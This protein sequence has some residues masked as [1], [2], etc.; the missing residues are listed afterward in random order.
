[1]YFEYKCSSDNCIHYESEIGNWR[2]DNVSL[3]LQ[4]TNLLTNNSKHLLKTRRHKSRDQLKSF[5]AKQVRAIWDIW[6]LSCWNIKK[7]IRKFYLDITL[8]VGLKYAYLC[9]S[10]W[11]QDENRKLYFIGA[12][13]ALYSSWWTWQAKHSSGLNLSLL[14]DQNFS[15]F[16]LNKFSDGLST[17]CE[18]R[19]F[20]SVITLWEKEQYLNL[21]LNFSFA[22]LYLWPRIRLSE[23]NSKKWDGLSSSRPWTFWVSVSYRIYGVCRQEMVG[24]DV[25]VYPRSLD[26]VVIVLVELPYAGPSPFF[27]MSFLK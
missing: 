20:H 4:V 22:I 11:L 13:G 27:V 23:K 16:D 12:R 24:S 9:A 17:A 25:S 7:I 26:V 19:L 21:E 18:G 8:D 6:D 15:K 1:M 14:E 10:R 3:V 2:I 5:I